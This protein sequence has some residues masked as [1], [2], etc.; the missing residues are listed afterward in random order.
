MTC[1]VTLNNPKLLRLRISDL[2]YTV[3]IG[4]SVNVNRTTSFRRIK[5][6]HCLSRVGILSADL[7]CEEV[8]RSPIIYD[9]TRSIE[10]FKRTSNL[11]VLDLYIILL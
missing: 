4:I 3:H 8:T 1:V 2:S 6:Y 10:V 11:S 7:K 5:T 9:L